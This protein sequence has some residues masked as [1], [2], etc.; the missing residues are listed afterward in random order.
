MN[1]LI[2]DIPFCK[3]G[4]QIAQGRNNQTL[5]N[6]AKSGYHELDRVQGSQIKKN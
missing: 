6:L 1:S 4:G 2:V 5:H 3:L